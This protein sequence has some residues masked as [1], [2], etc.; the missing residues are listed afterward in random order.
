VPDL[1]LLIPTLDEE[2]AIGEVIRRSIS[3]FRE[4]HLDY[5]I[6]VVDSS[7]DSTADI[8]R[9]L[10]ANVV[11]P[12]RM[13]YGNAYLAGFAKATGSR[14]I[15]IDGDMTYDPREIPQFLQKLDEGYDIVIGSRLH[16]CIEQGAMPA[17]H[18]YVGNPA[19]TGILNLLFSPGI[20]DAHCGM[21]AI[22][23]DALSRLNLHSGGMEI[24]SEMVIEASRRGLFIAEIPITYYKRRGRS[25]LCSISDGWRHLRFMMMYRPVPFLLLPGAVAFVMGMGLTSL[26][27]VGT[28]SSELRM[29]SLIL[30]SLILLI[31]YQT[32]LSG[33]YF[34]AFAATFGAGGG[35]G[36]TRI[37]SWILSYH[38]LERALL[39][40]AVLLGV[41]VLIGLRLLAKWVEVGYGSLSEVQSAM[42]A[43]ILC[44]MGLQ[45][46]FSGF[47]IS[48][49]LL[50]GD[51]ANGGG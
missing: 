13:G 43:L 21:R 45:T 39:L 30:G 11:N 4:L 36:G 44:I 31:G 25:K 16:G 48:L 15:L 9:S 19:L 38:S 41:G 49:L 37:A 1:S 42:L 10:G 7:R 20:S 6:I 47:S 28:R 50:Q 26:V 46:I 23:R 40:G 24:A 18:R 2:E 33:M 8:A 17:L 3:V 29:H 34:S 5:E 12:D 14:L 27:M 51:A 22:T 32:I 35:P